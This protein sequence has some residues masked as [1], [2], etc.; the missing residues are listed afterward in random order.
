MNMQTKPPDIG[1][2]RAGVVAGMVAGQAL[3]AGVLVYGLVFGVLASEA[4]LTAVEAFLMSGFIYS[5]TAQMA[6]L[7]G[8]A[9]TRLLLP[10]IATILIMNAR[11]VLYGAALRPWMGTLPPHVSYPS[12]F[13]L[14]DGNWALSMQRRAAGESDAGFVLGSGLVMFVPWL[15][16]TLAGNLLGSAIPDPARFGLDFMLVAF[17]AAL[18]VSV[19][20][21]RADLRPALA[22]LVVA[23]LVNQFFPGGWT[24]VAAGLAGALVTYLTFDEV[25]RA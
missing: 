14:A 25:K 19:F 15:I 11:Y 1:F 18:G 13:F 9:H 10:A 4:Q 7:Q 22:A 2:T 24:I 3:A 5:G 17:S 16:G 8:W 23:L 21:G 12:L 20:R 6:A